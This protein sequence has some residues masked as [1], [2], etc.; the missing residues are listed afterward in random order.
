MGK[1]PTKREQ[2]YTLWVQEVPITQISARLKV[3]RGTVQRWKR[4]DKWDELK[5]SIP[6]PPKEE[7]ARRPKLVSFEGR[8]SRQQ[9]RNEV[10][11]IELPN[12]NQLDGQLKLIDMLIGLAM[13]EVNNPTSPQTF[14]SS[15]TNIPKLLSE[16]R[17]ILPM[18]KNEYM[19]KMQ[20]M[21]RS[22]EEML[23]FLRENGWG[24][25]KRIK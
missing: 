19:L 2:A 25:M 17:A 7:P 3:A 23:E 11:T 20:E 8:E 13:R 24:G 1:K 16:R 5:E 18:D 12:L 21:F 15:M 10:E 14:A 22:P 6:D 4:E 9:R